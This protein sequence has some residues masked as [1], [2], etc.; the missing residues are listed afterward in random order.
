MITLIHQNVQSLGNS[1]DKIQH[2]L[3]TQKNCKFLCFTEHWKSAEQL[4]LIGIQ[5]FTLASSYCRPE[6]KHGGSAIYI[7]DSL[8][9]KERKKLSELSLEGEFECA[10]VECTVSKHPT[11]IIAIYRPPSGSLKTFLAKIEQ[12]LNII[13]VENKV[14]FMA[15]DFNIEMKDNNNNKNE[16]FSIVH[17]FQMRECILDYTRITNNSKSCI[18][19]IFTNLENSFEGK[20]F[21]NHVSDHTAQVIFFRLSKPSSPKREFRRFFT[22]NAKSNFVN[23]L[24]NQDWNNVYSI[25][26]NDV[27]KQWQVF[28]NNFLNIFYEHFPLKL[29]N[30]KKNHKS[31][32]NNEQVNI[33]KS[34]LDRLLVLSRYSENFKDQ[35]KRAKQGYDNALKNARSEFYANKVLTSDN[36]TKTMWSICNELRG[37]T[38]IALECQIK[39]NSTDVAESYNKF[40]I[41]IVAN[42][43]KNIKNLPFTYNIT[44]NNCSLFLKP[45]CSQEL[46]LIS[47]KLKNKLSS[48]ED[49]IPTNIVKLSMTKISNILCYILNNSLKFG[50]F[51]QQL[52]HS[53]IKPLHKSGNPELL[54]NYRPISLPPSFSKI[55]ELAMCD[56]LIDFFNKCKLFNNT[57]HGYL[58]GRSTHT[59]ISQFTET[60]LRFL[61][62]G[63]LATGLFVD[64]SKA[65]DCLNRE[66]LIKKLNAYGVRGNALMWVESYLTDRH[67]RVLIK[68]GGEC[69]KSSS[70]GNI[71]GIP[72]GSILGPI[73]FVIYINDLSTIIENSDNSITSFAD[74]TNLLIGKQG[75]Q[76]LIEGSNN[77]FLKA[78]QWFE[79]N[80]LVLNEEKTN[81]IIFSTERTTKTKPSQITLDGKVVN[82]VSQ[83]K[84]LGVIIDEFLKWSPHIAKLLGKL[85]QVCFAFRITCNYMCMQALKIMYYANFES[86]LRYGIIFWGNSSDAEIIFRIQKR[87]LRILYKM[88]F[89]ESC[90][91]VFK[92]E[93][94]LTMYG[95]YLHEC[96]LY[97]NKNK[98]K[99]LSNNSNVTYNT[100]TLDIYY[101]NH[102]LSMSEKNPSYMCIKIFNKL[103]HNI[104]CI[105]S[106]KQFKTKTKKLLID[107][108]PYSLQDYFSM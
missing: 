11:I 92:R 36:K 106:F 20:N 90:R 49:E 21:E 2:F 9:Y 19:N 61:E 53:L 91:G 96:L 98:D 99:F 63:K 46:I 107:L 56:R 42:L 27:N 5:N 101:P 102:R 33:C 26:K 78:K 79:T 50:I 37:R 40:L 66:Y 4:R 12:L 17:S 32:Y 68:K 14:M 83:A 72:Q 55:F 75:L 39:G 86:L 8:Q 6:G 57:Q 89:R 71:V 60:I 23:S 81:V 88:N 80:N 69:V 87:G 54:E 45:F 51:P 30:N 7:H 22:E 24:G 93:G 16:F 3:S 74:D 43:T 48:G 97:L 84:F 34:N 35:Y 1:V 13:H 62:D 44:E 104:K 70:I 103:P 76:E 18:D 67:Q 64:L 82:T 29:V 65:Y 52:K 47:Q 58:A 10:A 95:L 105:T 73:L 25:N 77:L 28:I 15:G 59:A 85:N 94:I 38:S 31:M 41:D 108:E 100:R